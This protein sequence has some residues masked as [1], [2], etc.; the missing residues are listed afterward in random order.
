MRWGKGGHG[1]EK[2]FKYKNLK[3]LSQIGNT[4]IQAELGLRAA[5]FQH[6]L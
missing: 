1:T 4:Q 6:L 2:A 5:N 3:I